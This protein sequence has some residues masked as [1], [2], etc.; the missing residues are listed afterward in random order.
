MDILVV[1]PLREQAAREYLEEAHAG[2]D[3]ARALP[4]SGRMMRV[5]CRGE[6]F[7]ARRRAGGRRLDGTP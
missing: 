6:R 1:H 4:A 3:V 2:W 5:E 7:V